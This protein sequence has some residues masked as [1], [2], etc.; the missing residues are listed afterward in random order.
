MIHHIKR[1]TWH[2]LF[3]SIITLAIGLSAVRVLFAGI[4]A[5]K[6]DLES[7]ILELTSIPIEI[8]KLKANMRGFN[9]EIVL[10]NLQV[11]AVDSQNKPA[12]QLQEVRL[13]I[14]LMQLIL[15]HEVLPS[16]W[17]TLVGGKLSVK[18]KADG[19]ISIAGLNAEESEQPVWL[20]KGG[21]YEV[22]QSEI[23][24]LDELRKSPTVE[25][26]KVDLL[27][28][29][30]YEKQ[31]HQIHLIGHLP[32]SHGDSF[33]VSMSLQGDVFDTDSINGMI[34]IE[35]HDIR[36][37]ELLA[38][39]RPAGINVSKG[40]TDFKLWTQL[41][42]SRISSIV[43]DL[44]AKDVVLHKNKKTFRVSELKTRFNGWLKETGW[45]LGIQDLSL[46]TQEKT[47]FTEEI[48][49]FSDKEKTRFSALG[50]QLDLQG[51]S[52]LIQ[53]VSPFEP[54]QQKL[55]SKLALK[56]KLKDFSFYA[57]MKDDAYAVNGTLAHFYS[58][59]YGQM[60][61]MENISAS[62]KGTQEQGQLGIHTQN[63]RL[64]FPELLRKPVSVNLFSG[65]ISWQQTED[66]WQVFSE[67]LVLDTPDIQ[68]QAK[69]KLD[70]PKNDEPVFMDLQGAFA[71]VQ[72]ISRLS[73]YYPALIM[74]KDLVSWLDMAFVSGRVEQGGISIQGNL[75]QFPYTESQGVFEVSYDMQDV[76]LNFAS[77]WPNI[78][79]L[80]AEVLFTKNDVY[81][82][83]SGAEVNRLNI[84]P[85]Q[86]QIPAYT[87]SDYVLI[88][89]NLEGR[90]FDGLTFL[91]QTPLHQPVDE[92]MDAVSPLG[93]TKVDLDLKI[94]MTASAPTVVDG[95]AHFNQAALKI[96]SVELDILGITGD[97]K[98]TEQGL[99]SEG[100]KAT[101]LGYPI[102]ITVG[103]DNQAT[104]VNV[105][106]KTDMLHLNQQFN[107]FEKGRWSD[108]LI[109]GSTQYQLSL[110]LPEKQGQ[111]AEL[112]IQ[113]GLSGVAIN[114]PGG[115]KKAENQFSPFNLR[116]FLN[117]QTLL[118]VILNYNKQLK[119]AIN[120]NK[121]DKSLHS[122]HIVYG[123]QSATIPLQKGVK[124]Q[125]DQDS[126][127]LAEWKH[128]FNQVGATSQ[129][130]EYGLKSLNLK[131]R[132]L[133]WNNK[134]YGRFEL[135]TELNDQRWL[136]TLS[137]AAAKGQFS[138]PNKRAG[139]QKIKLDMDYLNLSELMKINVKTDSVTTNDLSL[140]SVESVHFL[141]HDYDL[142]ALEIETEQLP[143][144]VRFK[145]INLSSNNHKIALEADWVK[146][147]NTSVTDM[148]G[149]IS[150]NDVGH[151]LDQLGF[152]NDFKE[153][154]GTLEYTG[155]WSGSPYQFSLAN[156][157]SEMDLQLKN[158]RI[159]SIEPG[160]GRFLGLIAMEQ[161]IK[162]LALNFDDIYK[163]GLSF[164]RIT[165]H[166]NISKGMADSRDLLIDAVP[167]RILIKGVA[168]LLGKTLDHEVE[169]V[170]KSSGALPIAGTIVGTIA[171]TIT[172][173]LT[174]EYKEGYFFGSKYKLTGPW[175]NVEVTALSHQ[176]GIIKKTWS[177]LTDFSWMESVTE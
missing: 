42:K 115:L 108:K 154:S 30:E 109:K 105:A 119:A 92:F 64:Y 135:D 90:V 149:T 3:W 71:N 134:S 132:Q 94:P 155:G 146:K 136:G 113:T 95:V 36:L 11:L 72:D 133:L 7:K 67:R 77:D 111:S 176:D 29:N 123:S 171:G 145:Q 93:L 49:F 99:F 73:N 59:A 89:G 79:R 83:I 110:L 24:W 157:E 141:W 10:T 166:F 41:D 50:K 40:E 128:V 57:N 170:P 174:N 76:E 74:D 60:P 167:A 91:Q 1:A 66:S 27:I 52:E 32:Q 116:L 124:V 131:T 28:K 84:K 8:G 88:Q 6:T 55:I 15:T 56:G 85:T 35:G 150:A 43:A 126:I 86:I 39:D 121:L 82:D 122:A 46:K 129:V 65:L 23:S 137:C 17:L 25:L 106:G 44:R 78:N 140:I 177:G 14:D 16:S 51:L 18:R 58:N 156:M 63:G 163:E 97:L 117:D 103:T 139:Q 144:G 21:R 81:I 125:V 112:D 158:G 22:L 147:D 12:I 148:K 62:L 5:Y 102:D 127:D 164:N 160:F 104:Y 169:V 87:T 153:T 68:T 80:S 20:L 168:N 45:H 37:A 47:W 38:D 173:A 31:A 162:R 107:F 175:D 19:S 4:E 152:D 54:A 151:F 48:G 9:P 75:D 114:L 120:I 2:I 61:Q 118:P 70:I 33:R 101:A 159:S 161:W 34:Y 165:G 13:G 172:Q 98:F 143:N 130:S 138:L 142:G 100:I 26:K 53:F 69:V 96:K